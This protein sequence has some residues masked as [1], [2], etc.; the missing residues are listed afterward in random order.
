MN[1]VVLR[2]VLS[3]DP[4]TRTLP[5]GDTLVSYEVTTDADDGRISV[6]V[7]VFSPRRSPSVAKGDEVVVTG[8][9]RRRFFRAGTVTTSRTE[10]VAAGLARA[11]TVSAR[12]AVGRA[13]ADARE[14]SGDAAA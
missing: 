14:G 2:G 4:R 8:S 3:S 12:R 13:L 1:I 7:V 5:S 6:P 9:V 10:V 11:G